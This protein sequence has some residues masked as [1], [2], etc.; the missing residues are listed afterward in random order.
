MKKHIILF[1]LLTLTVFGGVIK[2]P[3]LSID[4]SE[5]T[6]RIKIKKIDVGISGFV[7][8]RLGKYNSIILKDL[9]VVNYDK[10]TQIAT[11]KMKDFDQLVQNS[12]PTGKWK[13]EVGD[14]AI[15]A[16][17]YSRALLIAPNEETY[18]RITKATKQI[19][20]IHPD[21]FATILSFNGHP[22]PLKEDFNKMSISTSA[23]LV[24]FYLNQKL[25]T[26]DA[27][28][29]V[30]LNITKAVLKQDSLKLPFYS[31]ID[32]IDSSWYDWFD[33]GAE[34]LEEYEEYYYSLLLDSN[35]NNE[36][37]KQAYVQYQNKR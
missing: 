1:F 7:V 18:Y 10:D 33:E 2:T 20:W 24:F 3:I 9:T 11:L 8:H 16:F 26:V 15:L 12:L 29:M 22:T 30:I 32:K 17:G 23:G 35:P 36:E 25:F 31:R 37:L 14:I 27:K 13:V 19:Q 6:V 34:E 28:S 5:Q 4:A 21:L